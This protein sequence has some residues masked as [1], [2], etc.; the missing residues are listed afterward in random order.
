M[1][2]VFPFD[3]WRLIFQACDVLTA[4]KLASTYKFIWNRLKNDGKIAR[5]K[6]LDPAYSFIEACSIGDLDLAQFF[7]RKF[8]WLKNNMCTKCEMSGIYRAARNGH[9]NIVDYFVGRAKLNDLLFWAILG[10]A[11]RCHEPSIYFIQGLNWNTYKWRMYFIR[12]AYFGELEFLKWLRKFCGGVMYFHLAFQYAIKGGHL[13]VVK[14]A[15]S[16]SGFRKNGD[17]ILAGNYAALY[18]QPHILQWLYNEGTKLDDMVPVYA[19]QRNDLTMVIWSF[20]NDIPLRS[21][22]ICE[23]AVI[24]GNLDILIYARQ[25]G[26][27]WRWK[28]VWRVARRRK[29]REMI[30][31]LHSHKSTN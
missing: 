16:T 19:A 1:E 4:K 17:D 8:S 15:F 11:V 14:W 21:R 7:Q 20:E 28:T 26:V 22:G 12:A 9:E 6:K 2:N 13:D 25:Y 3:F 5:W 29:N 23:Y 27:P 31:W 18:G 24:N 10:R 30:E